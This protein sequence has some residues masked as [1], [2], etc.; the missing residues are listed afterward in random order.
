MHHK[1]VVQEKNKLVSDIKRL[2]KHYEHYEPT[3]KQLQHKY[4][5]VMKE[6]MLVK[7][8]RDRLSNKLTT[9]ETSMRA[10]P[11]DSSKFD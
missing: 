1:R 3:L 9:Y 8:E 10:P 4:E 7:L 2:K 6:K 5:V 11:K